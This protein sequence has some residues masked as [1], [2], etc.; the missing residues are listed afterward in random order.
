MSDKDTFYNQGLT[1]FGEGKYQE[2]IDTYLKAAEVDPEDG[3]VYL[4]IS[5]S[6]DRMADLDNALDYAR[7]A[8]DRMPREPLAYTNLSR[9]FQKKGMVPEAE[10]AMAMSKQLASGMM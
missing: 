10:E 9:I 4:A 1:L 6:Y 5:M 2:A 3:E 7:K 8:V